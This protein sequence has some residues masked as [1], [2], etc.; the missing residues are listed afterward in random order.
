MKWDDL[1]SRIR[2]AGSEPVEEIFMDNYGT[3]LSRERAEFRGRYFRCTF[4]VAR[5]EGIRFEAYTFA[6]PADAAEFMDV[7][8]D[9]G[10]WHSVRNMV[11][12]DLE[13]DPGRMQRL[14]TLLET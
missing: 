6:S 7:I 2:M 12:H 4:G 13:S 8:D 5:I 11:L 3:I 10:D 9:G 1:L 14:L